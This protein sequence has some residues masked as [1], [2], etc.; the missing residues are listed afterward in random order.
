MSNSKNIKTGHIVEALSN[1]RYRVELEDGSIVRA[2]L[3]G[4]MRLHRIRVLIGDK[5]DF[6]VDTQGENNRIIKRL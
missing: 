6:I 3:G 1:N 2:Y 4:K 5:V